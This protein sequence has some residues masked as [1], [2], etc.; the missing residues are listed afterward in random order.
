MPFPPPPETAF[1]RT[2]KPSS[3]AATRT[4][5]SDAPPSVPGHERHAGLLH[6]GLGAH[7]VA[8][9]LHHVRVRPDEDEIVVLARPNERRVLGEEAVAGVNRLAAGRLGG[10][11]HVRD[12][13]VALRRRRRADA[14][15]AVREPDVQRVAVGGGVDG[16]RFGAELVDRADHPDGDL[17]AIRD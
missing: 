1:S 12:P 6:L 14:D 5:A 7:L 15:G 2:G 16:D 11:D 13:E 10:C 8:H 3:A 4:S 17:A 9:P